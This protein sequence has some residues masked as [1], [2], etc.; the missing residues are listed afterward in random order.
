[1]ATT[2]VFTDPYSELKTITE[3]YFFLCGHGQKYHHIIYQRDTITHILDTET[4]MW[5]T[6]MKYEVTSIFH[7]KWDYKNRNSNLSKETFQ[8]K[9]WSLFTDCF[10]SLGSNSIKG[11][12]GQSSMLF[13]QDKS[14]SSILAQ[15]EEY[16][17]YWAIGLLQNN[18]L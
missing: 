3:S 10:K 8:S 1:M 15:H 6:Y 12:R 13:S 2:Y 17:M 4:N 9:D 7:R 18:V 16:S 14:K 5:Q 11:Y